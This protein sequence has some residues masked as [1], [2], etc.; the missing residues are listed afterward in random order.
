MRK[1]WPVNLGISLEKDANVTPAAIPLVADGHSLE[2]KAR[3]FCFAL[4]PLEG[5]KTPIVSIRTCLVQRE[6]KNPRNS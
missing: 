6:G 1:D 4:F 3:L 5:G 2:W